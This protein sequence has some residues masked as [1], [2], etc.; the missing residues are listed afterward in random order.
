MR[1]GIDECSI[2][3]WVGNVWAAC[4][5]LDEARVPKGLGD[6]KKLSPKRRAAL[7]DEIVSSCV[8]YGIGFATAKEIDESD[9]LRCSWLAM[10]RAYDAMPVKPDSLIVDG[11][12][13]PKSFADVQVSISCLIKADASVQE[14][15]A[16][17]ILAKV[18]RTREM[19]ELSSLH[20]EYGFDRHQGYGTKEHMEALSKY[21]VLPM[22]RMSFAPVAKVVRLSETGISH[23]TPVGGNVFLDLGFPKDEAE[24]L[25]KESDAEIEKK[26][27][28]FG[29]F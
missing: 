3:S 12:K 16:A 20:P 24:R 7:F 13:I 15:S 25:K 10:R 5:V 18:S 19:E 2:G 29:K 21:G 4:V 9:V 28:G 23:V 22:H 14:V 8:S 1:G 17:S 26:K 11:N 6:S 27:A